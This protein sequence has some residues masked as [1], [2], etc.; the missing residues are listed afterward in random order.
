[1]VWGLAPS[2]FT[3]QNKTSWH[4]AKMTNI[5]EGVVFEIILMKL[6]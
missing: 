4:F 6:I 2:E 3:F 5:S 1:M